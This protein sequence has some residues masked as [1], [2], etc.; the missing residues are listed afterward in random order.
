LSRKIPNKLINISIA[1][2][3]ERNLSLGVDYPFNGSIV[4]MEYY[5]KNRDVESIMLEINR[6]LYLKEGTKE[7]VQE[8]IKLIKSEL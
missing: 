6:K 2:F 1:F 3:K 4:P 7:V 5:K 8:Y